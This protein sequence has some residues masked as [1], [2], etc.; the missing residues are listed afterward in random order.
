[1]LRNATSDCERRRLIRTSQAD[2]ICLLHQINMLSEHI[3]RATGR[4]ASLVVA[5]NVATVGDS[6]NVREHGK[7]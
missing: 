3:K 1:M 5:M 4:A 7:S 6:E 2:I